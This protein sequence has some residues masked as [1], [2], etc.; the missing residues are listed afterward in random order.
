MTF[1]ERVIPAPSG[2]KPFLMMETQVTQ[3]LY[4]AVTGESPSNFKGDQY[5]WSRC[6]GRM[7]SP[8]AT[9]S[10]SRWGSSPLIGGQTTIELIAEANGFR[11]PF[12]GSG[13]TRRRMRR[14]S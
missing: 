2:G 13:S 9:S 3:A 5:L 4:R 7:G 11:L 1:N 14:E 10:Q 6:H 12:E 8:S